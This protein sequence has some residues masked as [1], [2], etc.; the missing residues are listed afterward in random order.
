MLW[1]VCASVEKVQYCVGND[2]DSAFENEKKSFEI[3]KKLA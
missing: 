1:S 3:T 2:S